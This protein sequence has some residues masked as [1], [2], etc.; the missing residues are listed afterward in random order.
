[1]NDN[2]FS[3]AGIYTES[4]G[5]KGCAMITK[6]ATHHLSKVHHRMPVLIAAD[7]ADSWLSGGGV[8]DS[9]LSDT[10]DY[11]PVSTLV[12]SPTNNHITCVTFFSANTQ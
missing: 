3:F 6:E 7:D 4:Q 10:I 1:M 5:E 12:K 8:F 11:Y 9:K 2:L